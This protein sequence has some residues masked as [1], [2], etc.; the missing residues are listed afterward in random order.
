MG[1][2]A[3]P[4]PTPRS[5]KEPVSSPAALV[6]IVRLLARQAAH[7]AFASAE[8][9]VASKSDHSELEDNHEAED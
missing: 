8:P 2:T 1:T 7:E 4:E 5:D 9:A 3:N 6:T